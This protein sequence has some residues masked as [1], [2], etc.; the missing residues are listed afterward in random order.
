MARPRWILFDAVGTLIRPRPSVAE[1]YQ[2][3]AARHGGRVVREEIGARFREVLPRHF[4]PDLDRDDPWWTS[5]PRELQRWRTI[6]RE[7]LGELP[8]GNE[9]AFQQLWAHFGQ[10]AS[11]QLTPGTCQLWQLLRERGYG[12]ALASNFDERLES[13]CRGLSPLDSADHI[14]HSA[15]LGTRKPGVA[16]FRR[17]EASLECR[18]EECVLVGDDWEADYQGSRAAGWTGYWL[19]PDSR[20]A[21]DFGLTDLSQ[22]LARLEMKAQ[23]A[24]QQQ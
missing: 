2:E 10:P 23:Q 4:A 11:W 19:H 8:G 18:P 1:V 17:I 15:A 14:F 20:R 21:G 12:L 16:F 13:I 6:V 9:S 5:T 7:V 3:V 22:L 24:Q